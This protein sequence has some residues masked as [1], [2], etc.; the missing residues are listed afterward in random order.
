VEPIEF[1]SIGG[2]GESLSR[3][4]KSRFT[5]CEGIK[6]IISASRRTD[7]PAFYSKWFTN[8]VRAGFCTV[9]NPF[10]PDQISNVSLEPENVDLFVF[11]TRNPKPLIQHIKELDE[12][13]YHYYFLYTLMDNPDILDPKAPP[14]EISID[15]FRKLS[16]HIGPEKVIWRYDPIVL[17]S[18]TD[19]EFHKQ[20]FEF[21][22]DRLH[23]YTFRC[24]ISFVDIYRK[25]E[26]R[27]KG[28]N[29]TGFVIYD[30]ND[31]ILHDFL[32]SMI[33]IAGNNGIEIRSCASK[34]DL[35]GFGIPAGKCI[36]DIYI[37]EIFGKRLNLKKDPS[38]RKNCNCVVSKD[39]G[40]Y[41]S[42]IYGCR[43]CYATN[44]FD[45]AKLNYKNHDPDST[46]LL[47]VTT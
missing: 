44:N 9:P 45:R 16:D 8:R 37:S 2:R 31:S 17:S 14:P 12:R 26:A 27:I 29:D 30:L 40:M 41:D 25:I 13:G 24:I 33:N 20:Q 7:I 34:K 19:I 42:C 21:I 10:N 3:Q 35:T 6:M 36:D 11:W 1:T 15:I 23:G 38:Q 43:Y 47:P 5:F 18:V 39:I 28:L 46:S 4:A 32:S 22:A